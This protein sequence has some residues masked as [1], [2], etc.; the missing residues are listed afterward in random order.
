MVIPVQADTVIGD[1]GHFILNKPR[2]F[3][4]NPDGRAFTV[5]VHVMQWPVT[6]WNPPTFKVRLTDPVHAIITDGD[7]KLDHAE[8][9]IRVPAGAPG[10]Y[11]LETEGQP[12]WISASLD[13][14]V[15]WTGDPKKDHVFRE[16]FA[17]VF[18]CVVPRTWWFYVPATVT[19][20]SVTAQ[21]SSEYM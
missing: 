5:T 2:V 11:Q 19:H 7:Q 16:R 15:L 14:A 4:N 17:P 9:V 8:C 10:A 3:L 12:H 20:F 21:R 18:Q 13:E 6:S 1:W